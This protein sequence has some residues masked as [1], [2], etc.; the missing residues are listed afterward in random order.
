MPR[1]GCRW[2]GVLHGTVVRQ[3]QR[4]TTQERQSLTAA[5]QALPWPTVQRHVFR[6][7]KRMDQAPQ[8]GEVRTVRKRHTLLRKSWYARLLAV[9]RV[10]QDNT[11][12]Q[13]AGLAGVQAVQPPQRL[14]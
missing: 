1:I 12:R 6:L 3:R 8:R 14:R 5:W 10:T 9:R 11:G 4:A 7:Q 13:T 2:G